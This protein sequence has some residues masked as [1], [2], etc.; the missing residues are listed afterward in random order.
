MWIKTPSL[1]S[2]YITCKQVSWTLLGQLTNNHSA[3]QTSIKFDQF[4]SNF[5][6]SS[7]PKFKSCVTIQIILHYS[8]YIHSP[9]QYYRILLYTEKPFSSEICHKR[10]QQ[11]RPKLL[12]FSSFSL[13]KRKKELSS[14]PFFM[15]SLL[16]WLMSLRRRKQNFFCIHRKRFL[17]LNSLKWKI[18]NSSFKAYWLC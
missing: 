2:T 9:K 6:K 16:I 13:W 10:K 15:F 18:E 7:F 17:G 1:F 14:L 3:C 4:R 11:K 8:I 12:Q 5:T